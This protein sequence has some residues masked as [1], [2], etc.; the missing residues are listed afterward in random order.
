MSSFIKIHG[1]Q[2]EYRLIEHEDQ[3]ASTKAPTLVFL[4]EGLGSMKMW[5]QFPDDICKDNKLR[6]LVFSRPGYGW[7]DSDNTPL[8]KS[9]M[10]HQAKNILPTLLTIL[11]IKVPL[12]I[13]HSDGASRTS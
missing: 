11:G 6:G 10:H 9:F 5:K 1:L 8:D 3:S 4:H 12:L 13:G 7:S 2:I